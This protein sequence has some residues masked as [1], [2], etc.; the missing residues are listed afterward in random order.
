MLL[1]WGAQAW[2]LVV[3]KM[4]GV[5]FITSI[6]Q[7]RIQSFLKGGEGALYVGYPDWLAKEILGFRWSKKVE[8]TLETISFWQNISVSIFK[9]AP[10][11]SIKYHQFLKIY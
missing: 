11:L 5:Y 3:R 9:F 4:L 6:T 1:V 7:G 8:V 2:T 10:F